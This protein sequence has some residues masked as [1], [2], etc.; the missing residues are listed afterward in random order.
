MAD[1]FDLTAVPGNFLNY[2]RSLEARIVSLETRDA[3]AG[4]LSD[5]T[6]DA[7]EIRGGQ[8]IAGEG[9]PYGEGD[10]FSGSAMLYPPA[11]VGGVSYNLVG[12]NAGKLNFAMRATDGAAAFAGGTSLLTKDGLKMTTG[13]PFILDD[14]NDMATFGML[15]GGGAEM[16]SALSY[17]LKAVTNPS[18]ETGDLTGWTGVGSPAVSDAQAQDGTYS[19]NVLNSVI[20]T[21]FIA[22]VRTGFVIDF[23]AYSVGGLPQLTVAIEQYDGASVLLNSDGDSFYLNSPGVWQRFI[24]PIRAARTPAKIKMYISTTGTQP[25]Y[26]DN[27]KLYDCNNLMAIR[28][29]VMVDGVKIFTQQKEKYLFPY[30]QSSDASEPVCPFL[31][32][33]NQETIP[34]PAGTTR[35]LGSKSGLETVEADT[36]IQSPFTGTLKNLYVRTRTAQPGTGTLVFTLQI[37]NVDTGIVVTIPAGSAAVLGSDGAHSAAISA[38]ERIALK[39]VNNSSGTSAEI[40]GWSVG[41]YA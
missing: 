23:W 22:S 38:G 27:I 25:L 35:Y 41:L 40:A 32:N 24:V 5:L 15:P 26:V 17:S 12:M 18:F 37:Q 39:A 36:A 2:M 19:C 6:T 1:E 28:H 29:D 4:Q 31:G 30:L 33:G 7:G 20:Y 16:L 11:V 8:I 3:E 34:A 9:D 21:G 13:N 14:G 10:P